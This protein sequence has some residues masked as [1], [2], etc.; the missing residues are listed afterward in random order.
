MPVVVDAV[1]RSP[2]SLRIKAVVPISVPPLFRAMF[3]IGWI[4]WIGWTDERGARGD[5][6]D[7]DESVSRSRGAD[8]SNGCLREARLKEATV[9]VRCR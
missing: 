4:G 3:R 6:D 7:R 5:R 2:V 8:P 1:E 9:A